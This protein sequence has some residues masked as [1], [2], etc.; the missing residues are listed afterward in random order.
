MGW[1]VDPGG[2]GQWGWFWVFADEPFGGG[3][4][5]LGQGGRAGC[6]NGGRVAVVDIGGGVHPNPG[7][8]VLVVVPVVERDTEGSGL[9]QAGEAVGEIG[10]V[11]QGFELRFTEWV[12]V[13]DVRPG[14]GLGHPEIGQ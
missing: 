9:F 6:P 12:V 7:V 4:V 13:T 3:C 2:A 11:L 1:W 10:P 14:V 8:A 5:G